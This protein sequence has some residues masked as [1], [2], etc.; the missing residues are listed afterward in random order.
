MSPRGCHWPVPRRM[1]PSASRITMVRMRVARSEL[2]FSTPILAKMAV[3]AA[4]AAESSAQ[5]CQE[6]RADC[7][8]EAPR[9]LRAQRE[10]KRGVGNAAPLRN[11][12]DLGGPLQT[13]SR[14]TH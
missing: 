13:I 5:S 9:R 14:R 6:V 8:G 11:Q 1:A 3:R 12:G 10:E 2:T 4:N 7:I